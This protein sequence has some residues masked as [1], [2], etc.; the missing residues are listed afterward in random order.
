M[1]RA[2]VGGRER[3]AGVNDGFKSRP[4]G[5]DGDGVEPPHEAVEGTVAVGSES[6]VAE[7]EPFLPIPLPLDAATDGN[8]DM[9]LF[10]AAEEDGGDGGVRW[11]WLFLP[12]SGASR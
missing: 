10:G 4:E 1:I 7:K 12:L 9:I 5:H 11:W 2:N 8:G 6:D 3:K